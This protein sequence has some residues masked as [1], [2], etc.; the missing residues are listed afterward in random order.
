MAKSMPNPTPDQ[1]KRARKKL[2]R[3]RAA[4][5]RRPVRTDDEVLAARSQ[6][7]SFLWGA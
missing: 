6:R 7:R 1:L 4:Q 3:A 2:E 5:A